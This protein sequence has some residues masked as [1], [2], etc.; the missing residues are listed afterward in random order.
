MPA[1][2][3][4][5]SCHLLNLSSSAF[6]IPQSLLLSWFALATKSCHG[7]NLSF[8][9]PSLH[10]HP[11]L[12]AIFSGCTG[13]HDRVFLCSISRANIVAI[14]Q[15]ID[16]HI[17]LSLGKNVG[18]ARWTQRTCTTGKNLTIRYGCQRDTG[19]MNRPHRRPH[20]LG[21]QEKARKRAV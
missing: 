4:S 1:H 8:A 21:G 12:I 2:F 5:R 15:F 7:L 17:S 13:R 6:N 19:T 14:D 18:W 16:T 20:C 10:L 3:I 11:A 9:C